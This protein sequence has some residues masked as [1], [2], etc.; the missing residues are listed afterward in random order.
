MSIAVASGKGGIGKTSVAVS[1]ALSLDNVQFLDC[2]VE[3]PNAPIFLRP[4]IAE[5]PPVCIPVPEADEA[6]CTH[7]R[8]CTQVFAYNAIIDLRFPGIKYTGLK[9]QVF[10]R[11]RNTREGY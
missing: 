6:K 7:C 8:K 1:L 5:V 3:E 2:D 11:K 10:S 9:E 4:I